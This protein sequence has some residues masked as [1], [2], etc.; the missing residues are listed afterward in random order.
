MET[1]M[2]RGIFILAISIIGIAVVAC[3]SDGDSPGAVPTHPSGIPV[4][5]A[6]SGATPTVP[7]ELFRMLEPGDDPAPPVGALDTSKTYT[8]TIK[9]EKG[10][11]VIELLDDIAPIYVENF[12]NLARVGYYDD[13]TFHRVLDNFMAQGG[14]PTGT[15]SGGPGYRFPDDFHP[16]MLHDGPGVLSMANSGLNTNGS[17]FFITHRATDWLNPYENGQLKRCGQ[18]DASGRPISCHAVF[19]R[20]TEGMDVVLSLTLRDPN[21]NPGFSGDTLIAVEITES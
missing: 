16:D 8:A 10:D 20:V 1:L 3:G 15:G 4:A 12:V 5:T 17:Q 14:D 11:I 6:T 2:K 7:P 19:G 21:Q 13:S 18:R 9:T